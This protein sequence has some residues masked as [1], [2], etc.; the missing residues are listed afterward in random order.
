[1]SFNLQGTPTEYELVT[2]AQKLTHL[3]KGTN[4]VIDTTNTYAIE[5]QAAIPICYGSAEAAWNAAIVY[6]GTSTNYPGKIYDNVGWVRGT[7]SVGTNWG[8]Y[9]WVIQNRITFLSSTSTWWQATNEVLVA[10]TNVFVGS[11]SNY[12][13]MSTNVDIG[14]I[15]PTNYPGANQ[16]TSGVYQVDITNV[17]YQLS[18]PDIWI[19]PREA[20][21]CVGG[22]NVQYTVVGTN[23]PQGVTW[24]IFQTNFEGHAV[25]QTNINW[26]FAEVIPGNVATNYKVRATSKDNTNF[27]DQVDLAVVGLQSPLQYKIGTN[28]WADMPDPLYVCKDTTVNFKAL[29]VPATASWPTNKP[30]W[31]GLL[32]GSG[33]ETN[34]YTFSVVSASTSDYKI[35]SAECGNTVTGKVIVVG[36]VEMT[37]YRPTTEGPAYN[38]P[39]QRR[40][41]PNDLEESPGAGI[42][43]NGDSESSANEND[44]IEVQLDV[45]PFPVPSGLTYVLKRNNSNIKVWDSQTMGAAL[46][47]SGTEATITISSSPMSVWVENPSGGSADLELIARSGT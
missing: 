1:M 18:I 13:P 26:H 10:I 45:A 12:P 44:L 32:S 41:V 27:Y 20:V 5:K 38:N 33:M 15:I 17:F 43:I 22:S 42:R 4:I 36:K 11:L 24:S 7:K 3:V 39:F 23:I 16:N 8:A 28:T 21:V 25:L 29:K 2:E 31:G 37:A 35:V 34:S 40:A 9:L 46:L 30:A 14:P 6:S 19:M 47:D